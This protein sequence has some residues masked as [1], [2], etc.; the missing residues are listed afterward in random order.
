MVELFIKGCQKSKIGVLYFRLSTIFV[1]NGFKDSCVYIQKVGA[2][3]PQEGIH[4]RVSPYSL[5]RHSDRGS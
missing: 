4:P 2:K 5:T 1:K 3:A